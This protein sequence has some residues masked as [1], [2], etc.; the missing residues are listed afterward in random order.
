MIE[1]TA[2]ELRQLQLIQLEMLVEVDRICK[3]HAIKYNIIGGTL[4]GSVRH[5]GFIPWDDDADL[6]ML[7]DEYNRFRQVCDTELDAERFYFQDSDNTEGYR[8]GYGKLRRKNTLFLREYQEHMPYEQGV[9]I[10]IF[11]LD[12]APDAYWRRRL[13][14]LHCFCIR[15]ILWSAVGR[16]SDKRFLMRLWFGLLNLIPLKLV[17]RHLKGLINRCCKIKSREVRILLMPPPNSELCYHRKWFES[18][19]PMMFEGVEL[20]GVEDFD[21]FLTW[22]FGDYMKLPPQEKRKVHPVSDIRLTKPNLPQTE[23]MS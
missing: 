12:F 20:Q 4:L 2:E 3:K 19:V 23:K 9:F 15:K 7:R 18:S 17:R 8:W 21:G 6:V 1:L 14:D 5:G 10:D 11:P 16:F 22:E 13:L